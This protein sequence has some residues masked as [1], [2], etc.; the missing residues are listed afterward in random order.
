LR[1][2]ISIICLLGALGI[3][4]V[5]SA[6]NQGFQLN[7]YEPTTAGEWS[8]W[9]DHPWYSST[10]YFAAGITLNYG[11]NPLVYGVGMVDGSYTATNVVVANQLLGHIDLAGS[12]LD[13]VNISLSL[14]ITLVENGTP[15][16]Y[17]NVAPMDGAGVGDPRF[18]LLVRI[19]GQPDRSSVSLSAGAQLWVPL[20]GFNSSLAP[21]VSDQA[22][23]VLPKLILAGYSHH[24][25]WSFSGGFLYRPAAQ[26]GNI[27]PEGSTAGSELQ[28][29]AAISYAD[30]ERRFAIGPE[31]VLATLLVPSR[32][33]KADATSLEL[34]LGAHYNIAS[35]VQLG[36]AGGL[37]ILRQPG[38]PDFRMLLR[39][40]YAPIRKLNR[41]ADGDGVLDS[42]DACP[43]EAGARTG[44]PKT[45][46]CPVDTDKDGIFDSEDACP[47]VA[48]L[49]TTNAQTNGCPADQDGDGVPDSADLCPGVP[50]GSHKD[51]QR[52]GCPLAADAD[53]DGVPDSED[54]CP[55]T[56][57][58][59]HPDPQKRG[60]PA[61]DSDGDGIFDYQDQCP[62]TPAGA[63]PDPQKLGC[64]AADRDKDGVYDYEDQCPEVPAGLKPDPQK[65]GCPAADRDQDSVS[66]AQDACPDKAGAPSLDPKKNGC[67][68][69][70][71]IKGGKIT[72]LQ[73]V[74]FATNKDA[75]LK[76]SFPLLAAMADALK[77]TPQIKK[78]RI[79]GHSDNRGKREYNIELSDRRVQSVRKSL[80]QAGIADSRMAAQGFGPDVPIADNATAQ[81]RAANRRVDFVIIDPPQ[82][83]S[84]AKPAPVVAPEVIDKDP[85]KKARSRKPST[86]GTPAPGT[87]TASA[88]SSAS[89]PVG[90]PARKLIKDKRAKAP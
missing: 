11:H 57:A 5:A 2:I 22:V 39:I 79:E 71:V 16:P 19:F 13:R 54:L 7:R 64:P 35:Q 87:N 28:L 82:L 10:R 37:G 34:L 72:V 32:A 90:K 84:D 17:G 9:V 68:G 60:C 80:E 65:P 70:V 47:D 33:F 25:R 78:I 76:K 50:A 8:F 73:P 43:T 88:P 30:Q 1:R 62:S 44:N 83:Q 59:A 26:L 41:D 58:G 46:G 42:D 20:R 69:M 24:V 45:N 14:P 85:D 23:R 56:P 49:R 4:T 77:A 27:A 31:A 55:S 3:G 6:Q 40:A 61:A 51:P 67:P 74:F 18:G 89:E 75:I 48:G 86:K 29:G 63:H 53:G 81:G 12:F 38:T 15:S 66:D 21:T 36:L 52:P